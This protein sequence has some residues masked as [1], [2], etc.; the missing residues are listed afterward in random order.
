MPGKWRKEPFSRRV[1]DPIS[2]YVVAGS[3]HSNEHTTLLNQLHTP[4]NGYLGQAYNYD[5]HG[6]T[7]DWMLSFRDKK[8]SGPSDSDVIRTQLVSL[9]EIM[10]GQVQDRVCNECKVLEKLPLQFG[11]DV[12]EVPVWGIDC[13]TR[14]M[15]ELSIDNRL[16]HIAPLL[17]K[18]CTSLTLKDFIERTVLPTINQQSPE[19]AH[20]LLLSIQAILQVWTV[21]LFVLF[22]WR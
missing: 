7:E 15:I 5:D 2:E 16:F 12:K 17:K 13:Y 20:N 4:L 21:S 3:V 6:L 22:C 1:Y 11:I 9:M 18:T 14:K 10:I 8:S 19:E